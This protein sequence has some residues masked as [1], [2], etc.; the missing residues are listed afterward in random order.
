MSKTLLERLRKTGDRFH[1]ILGL[2]H[3]RLRSFAGN[4]TEAEEVTSSISSTALFA[5]GDG[6]ACVEENRPHAVGRVGVG[7]LKCKVAAIPI[8]MASLRFGDWWFP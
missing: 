8:T 6:S 1:M 7:R 2:Q 4:A 5:V 3:F